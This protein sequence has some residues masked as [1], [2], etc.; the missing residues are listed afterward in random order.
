M[1]YFRQLTRSSLMLGLLVFMFVIGFSGMAIADKEAAEEKA[2]AAEEKAP[3]AEE[4][5]PA[6]EEKA[7]AAEEAPAEEKAPE[8]K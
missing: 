1:E 7:P 3:A 5:A 2:P 8:G 6:A 4:K